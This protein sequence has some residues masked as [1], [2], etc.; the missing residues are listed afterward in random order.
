[1]KLKK[2]NKFDGTRQ[3]VEA[4][5]KGGYEFLLNAINDDK[6]LETVTGLTEMFAETQDVDVEWDEEGAE[7]DE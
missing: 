2:A 5:E 4:Y 3:V 6:F 1:M 7:L